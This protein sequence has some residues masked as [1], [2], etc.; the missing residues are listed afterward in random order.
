MK[1]H[2]YVL[3]LALGLAACSDDDGGEQTV[4]T[5]QDY[6][7]VAKAVGTT[8]ASD[9]NGDS[10]ALADSTDIALGVMPIGFS[11]SGAGEVDGTRFGVSFSYDLGC[12]DALGADLTVCG[13]TTDRASASAEW[14]GELDLPGFSTSL[15]REGSWTIV[16]LQ[17]DVATVDGGGEFDFNLTFLPGESNE[18]RYDLEYSASYDDIAIDVA[19]REIIGGTATY[20]ID[21]ERSVGGETEASFTMDAVVD[22]NADGSA[23][24]TLDATHHYDLDVVTG[25]VVRID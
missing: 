22:F 6:D 2:A 21:A 12:Q 5:Q 13:P 1:L 19:T 10:A 11:L 14:S 18:R 7:D 15:D 25:V 4:K 9:S 20:A 3:P 8:V 17:S 23:T 16:G 24:L